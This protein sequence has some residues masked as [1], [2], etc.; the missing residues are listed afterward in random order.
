MGLEHVKAIQQTGGNAV[1]AAVVDP[2]AEARARGIELGAEAAWETLDELFRETRPDVVHVCTAPHFHTAVARRAL[3]AGC[4]VYVE[5]PFAESSA[6]ARD[7]I[8]LAEAKSLHVCSG[9]QLLFEA[10]TRALRS[11]LPALG[12]IVHIESCFA[13]RPS[14]NPVRGM[15]P[16]DVQLL[17]ILPHPVYLLLSALPSNGEQARVDAVRV[18]PGATVHALVSR[19]GVVANLVVSLVARPVETTLRVTGTNGMLQADY[20]RGTTQRLFGPGASAVEKIVNPFR[21]SIQISGGAVISL[22]RR[23]A[24]RDWSYPGLK[25]AFGSFYLQITQ[26]GAP[27]MSPADILDTVAICER[28]ARE[29]TAAPHGVPKRSNDRSLVTVTGGAG[30]LGRRLVKRLV[31]AGHPVR[32]LCRQPPAAWHRTESVD[33]VPCDLGSNVNPT[34][35]S[36]TELLIHCAAATAGGFEHHQRDSVAATENIIRAAA[37]AGV[38]RMVHVSSLG[39]VDSEASK[40]A[41]TES[42]PVFSDDRA[43]GPYVWGKLVSEQL[44]QRLGG[45]LSV[46]VRVVRPG[47]LLDRGGFSPPGRLGRRL[48]N[49]FIAVGSPRE[50]IGTAEVDFAAEVLALY[51]DNFE[52]APPMLHLIDLELPTR[53]QLIDDLRARNPDLRV[54]WL[55]RTLVPLVSGAGTVLQKLLK[56]RRKAVRFSSAFSSPRYDSECLRSFAARLRTGGNRQR[57]MEPT[58]VAAAS[59]RLSVGV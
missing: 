9:H 46:Q 19:G 33:Y 31:D 40:R 34:L 3:E 55:P 26:G 4:H 36:G 42:T 21:L 18:G 24:R 30:F 8:R 56:P 10:P 45:E 43:Q 13:F 44:V 25:E 51:A 2:S 38:Q 39:V 20:V 29:L 7:L 54:L 6:D 5:K 47:A 32:V 12:E 16:A 37:A 41:I 52:A 59:D 1:V 14:R 22:L 57:T 50:T 53:Q 17:D 15:L 49:V 27:A 48:A 11:Q 23:L 35:L 58:T 28:I